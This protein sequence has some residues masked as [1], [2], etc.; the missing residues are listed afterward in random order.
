MKKNQF[1][2]VYILLSLVL[3]A[4]LPGAPSARP[5]S[6]PA[7]E[8][9]ANATTMARLPL[10]FEANAG[11]ADASVEFL[12]HGQGYTLFLTPAEAVLALSAPGA[13][14][15]RLQFVGADSEPQ[16]VG[17]D[18]LP[19]VVNYYFGRDPAQWRTGIPTFARVAYRDLYPGVD[20]VFYGH[21]RQLEHD[22]VVA[23]GSDP[24][25]ITLRAHGAD[26]LD[27]EPGGDMVLN[28]PAG[29]VRL[30]RP[31]IYQELN[32]VRQPVGGGYVLKGAGQFG[33][34]IAGYDTSRPLIIDPVLDYSTYFGGSGDD[35]GYGIAMDTA[36]SVYITG[37]TN[38][39][40]FPL[41]NATQP[42]FGGGGIDCPSDMVPYR[43][44]YDVFV[45]KL[46]AA[47]DA[48]VYSTY[49]GLPGDD[50]GRGIAV[51][52]AGN[53]YVT[54]QISVN[55][56]SLPD[57]YIY[58]YILAAKLDA[59]GLL[60]YAVW[61]GGNG[62][63]GLGIAANAG[64][65][66]YVTG[67]TTDGFPTTPDAIQ[68]A[69]GELIDAFVAVIDPTGAYLEYSTYLGGSG[70]YCDV[71]YS[72]GKAIAVD[73]AG[74]I[75]VTGQAA[76]SFPTTPNA[77]QQT[78]N[79]FWKAFVAKI[80]PT[81]AGAAGLVYST[82]LGGTLGEFGN[83]I[84]LDAS[85]KVY[86]TGSTQSDDFPTTSGAFDRTCGTDGICNATDNMV[87]DPV[88]PGV[89]DQCHLD[90]K[91]DVFVAKLDLSQSGAASL[92]FATYVGGSGKDVGNAI[93]VNAAGEMYMTGS[94]VSPDFPLVGPVQAAHGGNLDA[95]VFKL[96]AAGAGLDYSTF[97][98]GG[99]DDV[100]EGIAADAAGNAHLTGWTGS[101]AFPTADPLQPRAGGW[102]AF[103]AQVADTAQAPQHLVFVPLVLKGKA[104]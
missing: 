48:L 38:S 56:E 41:V 84:A 69:A 24:G 35:Y 15:L 9:S 23:P 96:N 17:V 47:G 71:C 83:G 16:V 1:L 94:T 57:M 74:K 31:F 6:T 29:Q 36:G 78:F 92:V 73:G 12:A 98:G 70:A 63:K 54:G 76:P 95:F 34:Q 21:Q 85:G 66:A 82:Y 81:L 87:C 89:P 64:G 86:V 20:A 61:F 58:K 27:I 42:E 79:G 80:D 90:A 26:T 33:F 68:P 13:G 5:S 4:L 104:W 51:D 46:N 59:A 45:T 30:R 50:E 10:Q 103:V 39:T 19:G 22:F 97:I 91:A 102:E 44:C 28:M 8:A 53:A 101:A 37:A 99:G 65:R 75:Y 43:L 67:E 77:Y 25:V 7:L 62:S 40:D 93:A 32:G 88:P 14:V 60:E 52:A 72:S 18:E 100:G 49:L 3:T 55:S 2:P 11:Q